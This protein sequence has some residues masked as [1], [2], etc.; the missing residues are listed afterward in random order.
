MRPIPIF[1]LFPELTSKL[2]YRDLATLPT[3]VERVEK[4][5]DGNADVF[6]KRDDLTGTSYGGNKVRKLEFLIGRALAEGRRRVITVGG[7]G[8]NH[9]LCTA[10]YARK[11]GLSASLL[12]FPQLNAQ[13]VRENLLMDV[14]VGADVHFCDEYARLQDKVEALMAHYARA[15]GVEPLYIPGGG[16]SA[17]GAIGYVNAALELAEQVKEGDLPCPSSIY[18]ALG[19]M[20]TVAGL[21]IG[22]KLAGLPT[23]VIGVRVVPAAVGSESRLLCLLD[24]TIRLLHEADP[25]IPKLTFRVDDFHVEHDYFG[26][27]YGR[28]TPESQDAMAR[29]AAAA[30]IRLDGTYTGKAAAA[31]L[32]HL[33]GPKAAEAVLFWNTKN[34][35]S[36]PGEALARDYHELPEPLY[37]YF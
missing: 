22:L 4:L 33:E 20:G 29:M 2:P 7:A 35:R 18:V 9:A 37:E 23:E 10:V 3:P 17:L 30:G 11:A 13:S 24:E 12:L 34:S 32:A 28:Y 1:R 19:T 26:G 5:V 36:I 16:S 15:D 31:M 27:E 14:Y 25:S 21:I 8:S 6:V